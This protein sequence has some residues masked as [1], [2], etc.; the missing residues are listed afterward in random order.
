[1]EIQSQ[2][3]KNTAQNFVKVV[4]RIPVYIDFDSGRSMTWIASRNVRRR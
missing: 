4:Q 1:M 3:P 2:S